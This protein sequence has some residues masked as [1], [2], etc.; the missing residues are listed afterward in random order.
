ML[1]WQRADL[2]SDVLALGAACKLFKHGLQATHKAPII[3]AEG[4]LHLCLLLYFSDKNANKAPDSFGHRVCEKLRSLDV[5]P[6]TYLWPRFLQPH[7]VYVKL[8][9]SWRHFASIVRCRQ[10]NT[11]MYIGSTS[12]SVTS[13]KCNRMSVHR[14][15]QKNQ[16]VQAE[17]ALRYWHQE[18]NFE[19]YTVI[20]VATFANYKEAWVFEHCLIDSW[21]PRLNFPFAQIFLRKTSLG[22]RPSRSRRLMSYQQFG[23]RLWRKVRKRLF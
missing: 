4:L 17:L 14:K 19:T 18:Q 15:M 5:T 12:V 16:N 21:Q 8:Q 20:Q 2:Y 1:A 6:D 13:R 23:R 11:M 10:P 7:A 22:D 3:W 9:V